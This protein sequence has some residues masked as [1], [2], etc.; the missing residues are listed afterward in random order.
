[1]R[2]SIGAP[3]YTKIFEAFTK[4]REVIAGCRPTMDFSIVYHIQ[5]NSKTVSW[6]TTVV[7][8]GGG[9]GTILSPAFI[10]DFSSAQPSRMAAS[11]RSHDVGRGVI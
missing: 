4:I 6:L 1:M 2:I 5:S 11:M 7:E 9:G 10:S 8:L 3:Y